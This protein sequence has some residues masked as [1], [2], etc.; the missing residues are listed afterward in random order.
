MS[1]ARTIERPLSITFEER[2]VALAV[3]IAISS[4]ATVAVAGHPLPG[5]ISREPVKL[6]THQS[7]YH[8]IEFVIINYQPCGLCTT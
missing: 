4:T 1:S 7:I 8:I 2:V 5:A 3:A 6:T